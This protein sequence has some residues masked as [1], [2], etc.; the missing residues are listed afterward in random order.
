MTKSFKGAKSYFTF[1]FQTFE[2]FGII[3]VQ[4]QGRNMFRLEDAG[5][6]VPGYGNHNQTYRVR[7]RQ[8]Q[9]VSYIQTARL[10]TLILNL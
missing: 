5:E 8:L 4:F 6:N 2:D 9:I 1:F 10:K 7:H 3:H